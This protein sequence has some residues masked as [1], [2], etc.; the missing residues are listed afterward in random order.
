MQVFLG[1]CNYYGHFMRHFADISA[2]L[3]ALFYKEVPWYWT[4]T[5]Q[6]A[7]C[8]LCTAFCSHPALVLPDF[9]KPFHIESDASDTAIGGVLAHEH[10]SV[11]KPITFLR[12]ILTSSEQNYSVYN[13]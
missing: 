2:P 8:S 3:Y 7:M 9:T 1:F 10:A 13:C 11:Y 5:K 4:D 6:S 12:K